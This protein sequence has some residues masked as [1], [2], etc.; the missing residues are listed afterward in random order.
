MHYADFAEDEVFLISVW[1]ALTVLMLP[2]ERGSLGR[3]QRVRGK[4][5]EGDRAKGRQA[6]ES[7]ISR[8][9]F[10]ETCLAYVQPQACEQYAKEHFGG[11]I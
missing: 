7:E 8:T 3:D 4:Q 1:N 9:L 2:T 6:G 10:P 5:M 11:R